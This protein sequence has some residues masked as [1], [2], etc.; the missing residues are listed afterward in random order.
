MI[1]LPDGHYQI[2]HVVTATQK[3]IMKVFH[4]SERNIREQV[5]GINQE[6]HTLNLHVAA[7]MTP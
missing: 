5:I 7:D 1:R 4:L 6:L 3:E 2:D